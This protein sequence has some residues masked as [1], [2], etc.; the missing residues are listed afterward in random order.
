MLRYETKKL[1]L[2]VC[3]A[4]L[5]LGLRSGGRAQAA[6]ADSGLTLNELVRRVLERNESV[7]GKLLEFEVNQRKYAAEL[8]AFEPE[9][10][11]SASR[12]ANSRQNNTQQAAAGNGVSIFREQNNLYSTGLEALAPTG[13]RVRMGYTLSDLNNNIPAGLFQTAKVGPQYQS[14][15]GVSLTQ[16]LLKNF[17][18][19]ATMAGARLAALSSQIAFQEYRR[20]LM[21]MIGTAEA[22]YWNLHLAQEQVRFFEESLRTAETILHDNRSRLEAGKSSELEVL[23]AQAGA[24]LRRAKLAEARQKLAEALSRVVSLYG[25]TMSAENA[26]L[27]AVEVPQLGAVLPALDDARRQAFTFN[28]DYLIQRQK[29]DQELVR[30]GYARNQRRPEVDFKAAYG[31]NGLGDSPHDSLKFV[32]RTNYPSWSVG[33]EVRLPLLGGVKVVNESKAAALRLTASELATHALEIEIRNG[34]DTAWHK[35]ERAGGSVE[36]YAAAV[37]YNQRLLESALA[38]LDAGKIESRKVFEIEADLFEARNSV[39]ESQVRYQIAWLELQVLSG[40]LLQ[41]R[42]LELTQD[43]LQRTTRALLK[44]GRL[45]SGAGF[46]PANNEQSAHYPSGIEPGRYDSAVRDALRRKQKELD[47]EQQSGNGTP[48]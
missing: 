20:Q 8:G 6:A 38:R 37:N 36:N 23:E 43:D 45:G 11:G 33:L 48:R 3:W 22:T 34:M 13:T 44:N 40:A 16:P 27:R 26:Q 10:F 28:P 42:H 46:L 35:L 24:G 39:V 2:L 9:G 21:T 30:L 25:E 18:P 31:L 17:G 41:Q 15:A 7:Q 29:T 12:E 32:E 1:T 4:G 5:L 19:A 14:F 47:L